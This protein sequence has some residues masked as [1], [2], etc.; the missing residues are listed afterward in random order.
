MDLGYNVSY[1]HMDVID[2]K[3]STG[4]RKDIQ[5]NIL[6]PL[7]HKMQNTNYFFKQTKKPP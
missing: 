5:L 3:K 6:C 4:S 1:Q 2:T 7:L